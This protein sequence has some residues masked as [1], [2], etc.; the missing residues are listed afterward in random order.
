M[1]IKFKKKNCTPVESPVNNNLL[2]RN[3]WFW[4]KDRILSSHLYLSLE[5][6]NMLFVW[7]TFEVTLHL[8]YVQGKFYFTSVK[9]NLTYYELCTYVNN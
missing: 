4:K 8:L 2:V 5:Y 6:V 7:T 3:N 9:E 1:H